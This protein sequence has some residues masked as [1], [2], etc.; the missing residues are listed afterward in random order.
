MRDEGRTG[1]VGGG[2]GAASSEIMWHGGCCFGRI[3]YEKYSG[4]S[5]LDD[6]AIIGTDP[7]FPRDSGGNARLR[8]SCMRSRS[9][10]LCGGG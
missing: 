10:C 3:P 4:I 9:C 6:H 5:L 2:K 8:A 7:C 1:G